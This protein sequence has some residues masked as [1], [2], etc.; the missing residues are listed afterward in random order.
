MDRKWLVHHNM[1]KEHIHCQ[2]NSIYNNFLNSFFLP[3]NMMFS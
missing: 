2:S 1:K 3:P